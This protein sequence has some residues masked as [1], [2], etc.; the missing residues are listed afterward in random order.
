MNK[1][2]SPSQSRR[3]NALIKKECCNQSDGNCL[4]LDDGDACVCPQLISGSLLCKWCECAVL[5]LNKELYAEIYNTEDRRKCTLCGMA[6]VS[7]S[8]RV[9]YCPDCRKQVER[10][11]AKERKQKQRAM[12]RDRGKKSLAE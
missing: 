6:F 1:R 5:P 3:L 4:L 7:T 12:S 2:L 11:Q 8:N 10:R 9:K